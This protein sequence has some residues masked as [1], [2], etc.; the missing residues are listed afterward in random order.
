MPGIVIRRTDSPS[1]WL[2]KSNGQE[3][4]PII[5]AQIEDATGRKF[6]IFRDDRL[7]GDYL[8]QG[9]TD[10]GNAGVAVPDGSIVTERMEL[11]MTEDGFVLGLDIV[12]GTTLVTEGDSE[13]WT[14]DGYRLILEAV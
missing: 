12:A 9:S 4:R 14:E 13:L 11:L 7:S 5:T 8:V 3:W 10:G 6:L 1:G 2:E